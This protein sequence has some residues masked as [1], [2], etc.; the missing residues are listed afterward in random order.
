ML[1]CFVVMSL[2]DLESE[3][4]SLMGREIFRCRCRRSRASRTP[5]KVGREV[6][7]APDKVMAGESDLAGVKK[8]ISDT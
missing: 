8:L 7:G 6:G 5:I 2:S 4:L 1:T 3:P